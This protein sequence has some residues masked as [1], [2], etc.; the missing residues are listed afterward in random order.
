MILFS[1]SILFSL[2]LQLVTVKHH[3][4]LSNGVRMVEVFEL[5][6]PFLCYALVNDDLSLVNRC[7]VLHSSH[8][9]D[10]RM[11]WFCD[12]CI[13]LQD[14]KWKPSLFNLWV[15]CSCDVQTLI[16]ICKEFNCEIFIVQFFNKLLQE[17]N[18]DITV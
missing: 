8:I 18:F 11:S 14:T 15:G 7:E 16:D 6:K 17:D 5:I 10:E 3:L 2:L 4:E 13:L 1:K 9:T 12:C